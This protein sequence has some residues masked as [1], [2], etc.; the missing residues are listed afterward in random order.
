MADNE[1]EICPF[2]GTDNVSM[3]ANTTNTGFYVHCKGCGA[4]GPWHDKMEAAA[5]AWNR[6]FSVVSEIFVAE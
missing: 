5:G 3:V 4:D 2:C 1:L 6:R